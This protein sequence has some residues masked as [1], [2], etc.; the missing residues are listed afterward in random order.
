[1]QHTQC[2]ITS[3]QFCTAGQIA[4]DDSGVYI[5]LGPRAEDSDPSPLLPGRPS[6]PPPTPYCWIHI[7][8]F[9]FTSILNNGPFLF[10]VLE[11]QL[12]RFAIVYSGLP[13]WCSG[14]V[15]FLKFSSVFSLWLIWCSILCLIF[16]WNRVREA[17]CLGYFEICYFASPKFLHLDVI[18]GQ[19]KLL[20]EPAS[21]YIQPCASPQTCAN[22]RMPANLP[23]LAEKIAILPQLP[24]F[25]GQNYICS[26][27]HF[28]LCFNLISNTHFHRVSPSVI[29]VA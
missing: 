4:L 7:A 5:A 24:L 12:P 8:H 9:P 28:I 15:I 20:R 22:M 23:I 17:N 11:R 10:K 14:V 2:K 25:S 29:K 26:R 3:S 6:L 21:S 19:I 13:R 18:G 1:M 27:Q 16:L